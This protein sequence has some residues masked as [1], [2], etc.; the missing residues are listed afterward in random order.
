MV[1]YS[2]RGTRK[3]SLELKELSGSEIG[4]H[5]LHMEP[6]VLV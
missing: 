2:L 6:A 4:L 3:R 1:C 5:F